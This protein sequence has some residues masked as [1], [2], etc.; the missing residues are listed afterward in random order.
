M[1]SGADSCLL[2]V[3]Q[4]SPRRKLQTRYISQKLSIPEVPDKATVRR[5]FEPSELLREEAAFL[6][7]ILSTL[8]EDYLLAD[9]AVQLAEITHGVAV[10][11]LKDVGPLQIW[12]ARDNSAIRPVIQAYYSAYEVFGGFV[13]DYV[14]NHIYQSISKY[15]PSSTREGLDALTRVLQRNREM[16]RYEESELGDIEP[17]LGDFLAGEISLAQV[18]TKARSSGRPATQTVNH[19]QVGSVEEALPDVVQSPDFPQPSLDQGYNAAP[20]I[21]RT[22]T[23]CSSKILTT[24]AKHRQLNNFSMFLGLSDGITRKQGDFFHYPHTTKI[25]WAGHR[26][27][28]IFSDET[29]RI[30][31]YYDIELREA[32]EGETASG[33]MFPTTTLILKDRIYV[34]VPELLEP[35]FRPVDGAKEFFVR[36]DLIVASSP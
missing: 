16:Y 30:A 13:K 14:R 21:L 9:V 26:I 18:L 7:R 11:V 27:V 5:H 29:G 23:S 32:L 10:K 36:F 24:K 17:L 3:S 34:P 2:H 22:D 31:L 6:A 4:A 25:I 20:P 15:V 28:Y 1:F 12:I 35:A 19:D 8:S 33:G